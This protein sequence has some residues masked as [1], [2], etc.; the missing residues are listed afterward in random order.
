MSHKIPCEFVYTRHIRNYQPG[1]KCGVLGC[2]KHKQQLKIQM[3]NINNPILSTTSTTSTTTTITSIKSTNTNDVSNS[4]NNNTNTNNSIIPIKKRKVIDQEPQMLDEVSIVPVESYINPTFDISIGSIKRPNIISN[5]VV[6]NVPESHHTKLIIMHET[7]KLIDEILPKDN[8]AIIELEKNIVTTIND[9]LNDYIITD[10]DN[11]DDSDNVC[12]E[13]IR[14]MFQPIIHID[15]NWIPLIQEEKRLYW[16]YKTEI[17]TYKRFN[18]QTFFEYLDA[19][20]FVCERLFNICSYSI[21]N[22]NAPIIIPRTLFTTTLGSLN[23]QYFSTKN[24]TF[25]EDNINISFSIV[26]LT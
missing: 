18:K 9:I 25:L 19:D 2:Y 21:L 15:N 8:N 11:N 23:K 20:I 6:P 16:K 7:Y 24:I 22:Q 13:N 17:L 12:L 26:P 14:T 3:A 10:N 5:P 1:D 4:T